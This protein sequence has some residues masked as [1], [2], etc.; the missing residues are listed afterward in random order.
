MSNTSP[1]GPLVACPGGAIGAEPPGAGEDLPHRRRPRCGEDLMEDLLD[2][3]RAL[4]TA[5]AVPA[6]GVDGALHGPPQG[7]GG[8]AVLGSLPHELE[9]RVHACATVLLVGRR[10]PG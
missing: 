9:G 8:G 5:G 10:S 6:G 4:G 7:A 3:Y 2:V 1:P